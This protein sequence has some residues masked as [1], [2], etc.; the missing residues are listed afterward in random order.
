MLSDWDLRRR[1]AARR[2]AAPDARRLQ[3]VGRD[4]AADDG[5]ALVAA[6]CAQRREQRARRAARHPRRRCG[7]ARWRATRSCAARDAGD[8]A[9]LRRADQPVP[10]PQ[11]VQRRA[12]ACGVD[13]RA[14]RWPSPR[15]PACRCC[16][17]ASARYDGF[18]G[19]VRASRRRS[20]RGAK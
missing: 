9:E 3:R 15:R 13:R 12:A 19:I 8:A 5:S 16:G 20:S 1:A 17:W 7:S 14:W 2:G 4:R 18:V 11:G 10:R 6:R